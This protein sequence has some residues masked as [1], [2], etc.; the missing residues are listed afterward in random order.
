MSQMLAAAGSSGSRKSRK[1]TRFLGP[2]AG[3]VQAVLM[4]YRSLTGI[5]TATSAASHPL[6]EL[7]KLDEVIKWGLI[8]TLAHLRGL[9]GAEGEDPSYQVGQ[10][11]PAKSN[12]SAQHLDCP[13]KDGG[14]A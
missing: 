1:L 4:M 14:Y 6:G 5:L 3:S 12:L 10:L 11:N 8:T 9:A 13:C 7:N 2:R